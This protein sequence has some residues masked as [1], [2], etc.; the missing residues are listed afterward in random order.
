M[1]QHDSVQTL[2][3]VVLISIIAASNFV[4]IPVNVQLIL[5]ATSIVYIGATLSLK[6]KH[7]REAAGEKN[8][9]AM[10][11]ED[12]Y[13]F[14]VIG[15][16]MLLGLYLAFK[17]FDKEVVNLL[18]TTYFALIGTYSLTDAFSPIVRQVAF[19][20]NESH[21]VRKFTLPY[22]G[23]KTLD[24]TASWV[25]TGVLAAIFAAAW[26]QTKHF[27][28]NNIFATSLAIKGIESLS[29]GSY[30]V[31]AILLVG[32]FFYDIFWVF[33]TD[34]MVTVATKFDGPIKLLFPRV[35]ATATEKAKF[36]LLGLGDIVIPGIFVALL[37]RF[38]AFRAGVTHDDQPFARPYFHVNVLFYVLALVATVIVMV[39]FNHA[40]PALLY[41]V[42]GCLGSSLI[43]GLVRGELKELLA[44]SEEDEEDKK[45]DDKKVED[46]KV[47]DKKSK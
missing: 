44:Y 29:L 41:L 39:F 42:P 37:L 32:L 11:K 8:E 28:L 13:M 36:S 1:A 40:Q 30:K 47:E 25:V 20:E 34:V 12:A 43:Q 33:G 35:F 5:S 6:L 7:K 23:L 15:S 31:G 26:F 9:D 45:V 16:A 4:L 38:D 24:L 14:P 17:F 18:L 22:F 10:T 46:K 2:C 19:S 21:F 27:V 3:Y